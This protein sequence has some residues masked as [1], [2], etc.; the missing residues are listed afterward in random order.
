[1][2]KILSLLASASLIATSASA[3]VA[4]NK[5]GG[6]SIGLLIS[7]Y[8]N[9]YFQNMMKAGK[10]YA[11]EKGYTLNTYDSK[12]TVDGSLDVENVQ[13]SMTK[14]DKAIII[15]PANVKQNKAITPALKANIPVIN[16][17]TEYDSA[18]GERGAAAFVS[19]QTEA[20]N[21]MFDAIYKKIYGEAPSETNKS[22]KVKV[23]AM[24]SNQDNDAEQKRFKGFV[25]DNADWIQ[26]VNRPGTGYH[27]GSVAKEN[28]NTG[29]GAGDTLTNEWNGDNS[30]KNAHVIWAGNDP[31]AL[32]M[33]KAID[34][35]PSMK[36]W[37]SAQEDG[38][39]LRKGFISGFDGSEDVASDLGKW[40]ETE[41]NHI[42]ITV[43]QE[44]KNIVAAAID[45]A[46]ELI[47]SKDP[48]P[49][50]FTE[51]TKVP[52]SLMFAPGEGTK[53]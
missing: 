44:Y 12:G 35:S 32:G 34:L 41:R 38:T 1:M 4:C 21:Q 37:F 28:Q 14:G 23:Y 30:A 19:E 36:T 17:D 5:G 53:K 26:L 27:Q 7:N 18:V 22:K 9:A 20:S 15:N 43:K 46:I 25:L 52:A 10:E 29:D 40:K 45:K 48:A 3:V 39:N 42:Y 47:K 2:K 11:K 24:W 16:I 13:A 49:K 6:D 8:N 50:N 33:K 51:S 31:M